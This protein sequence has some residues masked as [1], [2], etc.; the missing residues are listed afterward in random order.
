MLETAVEQILAWVAPLGITNETELVRATAGVELLLAFPTIY[1]LLSGARAA[2][3]RYFQDG[4]W[5]PVM[6]GKA[7]WIIQ[8]RA[9]WTK[10]SREGR[11][12]ADA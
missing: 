7:A 12:G 4:N 6:N 9:R 5:G 2:Y 3:G 1:A 8:V 10:H 11:E